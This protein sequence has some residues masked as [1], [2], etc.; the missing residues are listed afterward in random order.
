[1]NWNVIWALARKDWREVLQN[2]QAWLP[3][4]IVPLIFVVGM[5]LILLLGINTPG[6][7]DSLINDPDMQG[8]WQRLPA[9]MAAITANMTEMQSGVAL[10]LGMLMAPMFLIMPIM[11]STVIASESFAGE[12]ERKTLEA[13][14]YTPVSDAELFLGKAL[15]ALVPAVGLTWASFVVYILILNVAGWPIFERIWFPLANWWVLIFWITPALS[16]LGVFFTVLISARAKTFMGAYQTSAMLVLL[17][18]GLFAGQASGVL[19]L[20]VTTGLILGLVIWLIA[21]AL[22]FVA[23]RTFKRHTILISAS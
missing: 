10:F 1:M 4:L 3:M 11:F 21:I 14:L 9:E 5:P 7:A 22:A 6:V 20:S 15:A 18:V 2:R 8:F 23:I 19:Y 17:V 16:C 12:L 13:L